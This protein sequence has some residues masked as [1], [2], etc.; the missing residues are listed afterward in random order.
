MLLAG[1]A[2]CKRF[3]LNGAP[4][5]GDGDDGNWIAPPNCCCLLMAGC[6]EG[7]CEGW[8]ALAAPD[9]GWRAGCCRG[10][11]IGGAGVVTG[12]SEAICVE[13][14]EQEQQVISKTG[15]RGKFSGI[16]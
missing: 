3:E 16:Y 2:G 8:A 4:D 5:G 6:C 15:K 14:C 7:C 12:F 1:V 11:C 10:I 9:W 13:S